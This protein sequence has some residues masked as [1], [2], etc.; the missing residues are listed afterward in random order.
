MKSA[1]IKRK[2][3]HFFFIIITCL[4]FI[5]N[6][7]FAQDS[8]GSAGNFLRIGIGR[9]ALAMGNAFVA[10]ADDPSANYWNPA[11]LSLF[12][13]IEFEAM[14]FKMP[15][16][17][18]LHF[19]GT[20]IPLGNLGT[21]GLSWIGLQIINL[22]ARSSNT[23]LPD[24][25]FSDSENALLFSY[26]KKINS[27]L[28]LGVNFKWIHHRLDVNQASG[29][30]FDSA[31]LFT[32][33]DRLKVALVFY[34]INTRLKWAG[35]HTDNF[36]QMLRFGVSYRLSSF[37]NISSDIQKISKDIKTTNFGA[38]IKTG[39]NI[40]LQLGMNQNVFST[41]VSFKL[42]ISALDINFGYSF[43][44][45]KLEN[46][47]VHII[48]LNISPVQK[49]KE[50]IDFVLPKKTEPI[51]KPEPVN[52]K[53]SGENSEIKSKIVKI[54]TAILNVRQGPGIKEKIIGTVLLGQIFEVQKAEKG[55]VKIK[56]NLNLF[57]WVSDQY[58]QRI[59]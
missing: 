11:A 18:T 55:W 8:S 14:Y 48:S 10:V 41:G 38:E 21:V 23:L 45:D 39:Q 13:K 58:I 49:S 3:Y 4:L 50:I 47:F 22:E 12:N 15:F 44:T 53:N 30:G 40:D 52:I 16:D 37:L 34:D 43:K 7:I 28:S 36:P 35:G 51:E 33:I 1:L 46:Q 42:P 24:Y 17:R 20:S 5:Q 2:F 6:Q 9:R 59:N 19:I 32:P 25:Y 31:I 54:N 29:F 26:G 57:G 56:Y 27:L